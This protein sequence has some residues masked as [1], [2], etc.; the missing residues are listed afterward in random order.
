LGCHL[1]NS[2]TSLLN[3]IRLARSERQQFTGNIL[4]SAAGFS[5]LVRGVTDSRQQIA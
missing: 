3:F 5:N 4:G 1:Q 2:L